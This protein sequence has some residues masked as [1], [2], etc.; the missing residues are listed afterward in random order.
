MAN[1]AVTCSQATAWKRLPSLPVAERGAMQV[2]RPAVVSV[3]MDASA[4]AVNEFLARIHPYRVK[5]NSFFAIRRHCMSDPEA[6]GNEPEGPPCAVM[7][8]MVGTG[9]QVPFLG[10]VALER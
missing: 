4:A 5:D 2:R 9:D 1:S 3:N 10:M 6:G 8:R 7:Q